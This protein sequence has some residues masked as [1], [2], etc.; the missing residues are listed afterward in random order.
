MWKALKPTITAK[1]SAAEVKARTDRA[2]ACVQQN[3]EEARKERARW[4]EQR[5]H[6][7]AAIEAAASTAN[8]SMQ[9]RL[10]AAAKTRKLQMLRAEERRRADAEARWQTAK[11]AQQ[12]KQ[13]GLAA[14]DK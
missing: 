10:E 4:E 13:A 11:A 5:Q 6:A 1:A 14:G 2:L 9:A 3:D 7:Q 8:A 12:P